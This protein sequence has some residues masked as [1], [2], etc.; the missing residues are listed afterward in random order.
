MSKTQ[1]T[2]A[3]KAEIARRR[4][5]LGGVPMLSDKQM[6]EIADPDPENAPAA[7]RAKRE[8]REKRERGSSTYSL[9]NSRDLEGKTPAHLAVFPNP[10]SIVFVCL[11]HNFLR[12]RS[13]LLL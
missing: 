7:I 1:F 2:S 12:V 11:H 13:H 6:L 3:E 8:A 5:V 9:F 10:V 4:R